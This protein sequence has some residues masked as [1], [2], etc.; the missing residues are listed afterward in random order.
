MAKKIS[1]GAAH[2]LPMDL[3]KALASDS[4]ALL[5]WED[6]TGLARNEW[7]C[8]VISVKK[9]ETRKLHIER[10]VTELKEGI[11]RPCCWG[12]CRHRQSGVR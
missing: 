5:A 9:L 10:T 6:I 11:R 1:Q 12:G 4:V 7:I 8:W 2:A 3:R